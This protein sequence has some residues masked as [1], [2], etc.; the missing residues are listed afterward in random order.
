MPL[1]IAPAN[2]FAP[3]Y[4][5]GGSD[6]TAASDLIGLVKYCHGKGIRFFSDIVMAFGYEPYVHIDYM[7]FHLQPPVEPQKPDAWQSPVQ[8][9]LDKGSLR[10]GFG[11]E[12]WRYDESIQTY[13][14]KSG[15]V[16]TIIPAWAFHRAH[17]AYWMSKFQLGGLRLDSINNIA[18]WD[19]V[20]QFRT[21]AYTHF[22]DL[23]PSPQNN[24]TDVAA[25]FLVIGEELSLPS[26]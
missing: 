18:N 7:P 4:D 24:P 25:R 11:G 19:F 5:L 20:A 8:D 3:D 2:Y 26:K 21:D 22:A 12:S 14:P 13:D 9:P 15:K 16:D 10:D 6:H 23:Y 1:L 17:L